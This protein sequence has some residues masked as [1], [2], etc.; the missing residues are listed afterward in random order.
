VA[1]R[2]DWVIENNGTHLDSLPV[3]EQHQR[4]IVRGGPYISSTEF[5]NSLTILGTE[6]NN[7]TM[8]H[9]VFSATNGLRNDTPTVTLTVWGPPAPP[10]PKLELL[11]ATT[12]RLTWN[13]PFTWTGFPI[14]NYTVRMENTSNSMN[15]RQ[16]N[17]P[18][19][20]NNSN[21]S[22]SFEL[23]TMNGEIATG[24]ALL[25]FSVT[26]WSDLGESRPGRI[27]GG[28]PIVPRIDSTHV[29][30][31]HTAF[32]RDGSPLINIRFPTPYVCPFQTANF[33]ILIEGVGT[34]DS[35]NIGPVP[36]SYQPSFMIEIW[37]NSSL[38]LDSEY[39]ITATFSSLASS[40]VSLPNV[41][42]CKFT[43]S[44]YNNYVYLY[45][46]Q[47]EYPKSIIHKELLVQV[48]CYYGKHTYKKA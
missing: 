44:A 48:E 33:T 34:N 18:A 40:N 23:S 38:E 12:L 20:E 5:N 27:S 28:F 6:E 37:V 4:G 39:S 29:M 43:S 10:Q 8:I 22:V 11:N 41:T 15:N 25:N 45:W 26:A 32:Q 42:V 31:I 47:L 36:Y 46:F 17:I 2:V 19:N 24:C 13:P 35:I 14:Q 9:C 7:Q 30:K 1:D 21:D 3:P 16:W